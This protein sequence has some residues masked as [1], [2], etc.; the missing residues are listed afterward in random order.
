[1]PERRIPLWLW[2]NLLSL[3]API[4]AVVWLAMFA[5]MWL[6][7]LEWPHYLA[8]GLAVWVIYMADRLLDVKLLHADDPRL[9]PRHAFVKRHQGV[10]GWL[11]VV[12]ALGCVYMA[13]FVLPALLIGFP[14]D[15]GYLLPAIIFTFVFFSMNLASAGNP[16][17]PHLRNLVAGVTFSFG[18]AMLAHMHIGSEG[19]FHL[20]Q[21]REMLCFALLCAVNISAIH[22][23]EQSRQSRDE[24]Y[25]AAHELA[26]TL[27]LAVLGAACILS[28][29]LDEETTKRPFFYAV[30][31]ATALL[32]VLNRVRDR[33]SMDALRVL[34]DV[35]LIVPFPIF[36]MLSSAR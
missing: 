21:S 22:F 4:V 9:G 27:P 10:L 26:L 12:A 6:G 29:G 19:V 15:L 24:D 25:Q 13:F 5:R 31:I 14:S 23:W 28:A 11:T 7:L 1:M 32:F 8:L 18:T 30:L 33:F 3:D 16:E 34:A 17:I 35:A 2:P 36:W 20:I